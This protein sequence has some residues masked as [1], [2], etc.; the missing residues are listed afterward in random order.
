MQGGPDQQ[1]AHLPDGLYYYRV[2][3]PSGKV[4]LYPDQYRTV[5]VSNNVFPPTQLSPFLTSANSGDEYKAWISTVPTF[6][7]NCSKTDNFK[8]SL[9]KAK[10]GD[11]TGDGIVDQKDYIILVKNYNKHVSGNANGD[12]DNNGIVDK[13]DYGIWS[14]N[15]RP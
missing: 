9:T 10:P 1:G 12:F 7:N 8:V 15:Y 11:A 2:T 3:D 5:T 13:I 4:I 14:K 6:E